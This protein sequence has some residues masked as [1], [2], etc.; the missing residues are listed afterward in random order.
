MMVVKGRQ[1][2]KIVRHLLHVQIFDD[3]VN[4]LLMPKVRPSCSGVS[5]N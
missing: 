3:L 1:V 2:I 5:I 4:S